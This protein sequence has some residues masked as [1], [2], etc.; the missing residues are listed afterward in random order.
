MKCLGCHEGLLDLLD[1]IEGRGFPLQMD[2]GS[3][4][5]QFSYFQRCARWDMFHQFCKAGKDVVACAVD[6]RETFL[7]LR[8]SI[9]GLVQLLTRAGAWTE[10]LLVLC[11]E[12]SLEVLDRRIL[13]HHAYGEIH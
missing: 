7:H 12:P 10:C 6:N 11:L 8:N 4:D 3:V 1:R 13:E 9:A 2:A 5:R